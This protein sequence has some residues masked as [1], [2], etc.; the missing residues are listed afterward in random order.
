MSN[1]AGKIVLAAQ[2]VNFP[3]D[4]CLMK[5]LP[6]AN[7]LASGMSGEENY[8]RYI[9]GQDPFHGPGVLIGIGELNAGSNLVIKVNIRFRHAVKQKN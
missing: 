9:L 2:P 4:G 5:P 8:I 3:S 6:I 1:Q 7:G